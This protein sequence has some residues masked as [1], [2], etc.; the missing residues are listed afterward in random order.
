MVKC[1]L[2][3]II[4][5]KS[6]NHQIIKSS[7]SWLIIY[8]NFMWTL[9]RG[10]VGRSS[11]PCLLTRHVWIFGTP[12]ESAKRAYAGCGSRLNSCYK[13]LKNENTLPWKDWLE[14]TGRSRERCCKK[15]ADDCLGMFG[16]TIYI[17]IVFMYIIYISL[18]HQKN[19][20]PY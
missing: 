2:L 14:K 3:I 18:S 9:V 7:S 13:S 19:R 12:P 5:I 10:S 17:Y 4:I 1:L 20:N 8:V 11:S 6:S 16:A 15:T